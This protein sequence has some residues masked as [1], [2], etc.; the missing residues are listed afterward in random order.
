M[1]IRHLSLSLT[2]GY[3]I[4]D[5]QVK[6]IR[7]LTEEQ[8]QY[9]LDIALSLAEND[10]A[11]ERSLFIIAT[12]KTLFLRISELSERKDWSPEMRH[13]CKMKTIIGGL[14]STVKVGNY[15]M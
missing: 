7:R 4:A 11:Y 12:L 8:W 6:E 14:K 2:A 3:F 15:V 10:C 9:V 13:F 5:A 1:A